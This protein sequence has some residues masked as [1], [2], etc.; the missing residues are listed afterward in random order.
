MKIFAN[1]KI[2]PEEIGKFVKFIVEEKIK[3]ILGST[4]Y[5]DGNLNKSYVKLPIKILNEKKNYYNIFFFSLVLWLFTSN[6]AL[7][8]LKLN[9]IYWM[10]FGLNGV[11]VTVNLNTRTKYMIKLNR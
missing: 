9:Y 10:V 11:E 2:E 1:K 5:F 4:V 8:A 6:A 3:Y 7:D